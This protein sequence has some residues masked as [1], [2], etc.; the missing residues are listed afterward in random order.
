MHASEALARACGHFVLL[1]PGAGQVLS[2]L[3]RHPHPRPRRRS[4]LALRRPGKG[5]SAAVGLAAMRAGYA[6]R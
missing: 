2:A 5:G 6:R 3:E 1:W 4:Q